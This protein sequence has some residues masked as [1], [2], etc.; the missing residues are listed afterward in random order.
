MPTNNPTRQNYLNALKGTTN[1]RNITNGSET[2]LDPSQINFDAAKDSVGTNITNAQPQNNS[3]AQQN[4]DIND[5][6]N[7][8]ETTSYKEL[9]SSKIQSANAREEAQKYAMNSLSANG[10]GNTGIAQST[11]LGIYNTYQQALN[12]AEKI[13]Q[14]NLFDIESQRQADLELE[15][16]E[17]FQ[18]VLTMLSQSMN[19]QDLMNVKNEFYNT[20]SDSQKRIFDYYYS[21]YN[22]QYRN[23]F[24]NNI[25][26][27]ATD[28]TK[29]TVN[30]VEA[31]AA[32]VGSSAASGNQIKNWVQNEARDGDIFAISNGEN[33]TYFVYNNGTIYY[34][35]AGLKNSS[36]TF[37]NLP[38]TITF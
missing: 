33:N 30:Q 4:E 31:L 23:Q 22:S 15:S 12:N 21:S 38:I 35:G 32:L 3:N 10:L 7:A 18:S 29:V 11:Q 34:A 25:V 1:T 19:A 24:V 37:H 6:Y 14:Q 26:A 2:L 36:N 17:N 8:L 9:L 5:K 28:G 13:H 27:N 16:E 20:L